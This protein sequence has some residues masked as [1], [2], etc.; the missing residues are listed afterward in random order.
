MNEITQNNCLN[1]GIY[2]Q[3]TE[4]TKITDISNVHDQKSD[5]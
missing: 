4:E 5:R 1:Q 3:E 2:E